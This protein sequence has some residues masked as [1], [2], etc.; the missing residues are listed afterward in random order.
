TSVP[1]S[2]G[3]TISSTTRSGCSRSKRSSACRPSAA[4]RTSSPACSR[5]NAI[6]SRMCASSSTTRTFIVLRILV[7]TRGEPKPCTDSAQNCPNSS[8][9]SSFSRHFCALLRCSARARSSSTETRGGIMDERSGRPRSGRDPLITKLFFV[10]FL[11][12]VLLL[13]IEWIRGII[14]E[15]EARHA[16]VK[17]EL[18][19]TWGGRQILSGPLLAVPYLEHWKSKEGEAKT[20]TCFG[21]F[22]PEALRVDGTV[23]PETRRRGI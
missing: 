8:R 23:D 20:R 13:P 5:V 4:S 1:S 21:Y 18:A 3:I 14:G 17:Q 9:Q 22:L 15:R 16:A 7:E 2:S 12:L 10:G 11:V 19:G 6:T